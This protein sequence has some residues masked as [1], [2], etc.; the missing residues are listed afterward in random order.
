MEYKKIQSNYKEAYG[1]MIFFNLI[2]KSFEIWWIPIG[3]GKP[4]GKNFYITFKQKL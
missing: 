4:S 3:F 1:K 2:S